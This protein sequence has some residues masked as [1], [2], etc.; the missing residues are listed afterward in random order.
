MS[1]SVNY[2]VILVRAEID[3]FQHNSLFAQELV[4]AFARRGWK[5]IIL[6][7]IKDSKKVFEALRDANCK[8]FLSFNGFGTELELPTIYP[9]R[10]EAAFQAFSKPVL[11][12]MH[13]CPFHE[14]MAHQLQSNYSA[15]RLFITDYRYAEMASELGV[16]VVKPVPS[17]TFPSAMETTASSGHRDVEILFAAGFLIPEYTHERFQPKNIKGRTYKYIFE[18]ITSECGADWTLDPAV[19]LKRSLAELGIHLNGLDVDHRF[20][21]TAT[22][23]YVKFDRRYKILECL[24]GLPITLV[25]DRKIDSEKLWSEVNLLEARTAADLLNLMARSRVVLCP[26]THMTGFHERPLSAFTAGAAVVSTPCIPLQTHFSH[27]EDI[28]MA[29]HGAELRSTLESLLADEALAKRVGQAGRQKAA[30][31]FHPDRLVG[32]LLN[33][34]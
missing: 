7:Y 14:S 15:R 25:A 24:R 29:R 1:E 23:D 6:D 12:L 8:F 17:I 5:T 26:T 28:F 34:I 18:Q 32:A 16:R 31:L 21:L 13:D 10:L 33:E 27:G 2:L 20:L 30:E 9:G 19:E 22:L 4:A 11:D 3:R